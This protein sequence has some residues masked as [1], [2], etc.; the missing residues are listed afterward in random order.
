MVSLTAKVEGVIIVATATSLSSRYVVWGSSLGYTGQELESLRRS[1]RVLQFTPDRHAFPQEC[2]C[3]LTVSLTNGHLRTQIERDGNTAP[4]AHS[5][6]KRQAV[7][8]ETSC[9]PAIPL[10]RDNHT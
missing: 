2:A 4:V 7:L 1:F 10:I 5:S 3:Q 6:L 9:C 8:T